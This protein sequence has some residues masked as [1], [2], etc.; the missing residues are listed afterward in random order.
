[1]LVVL[2]VLLLCV[3][4][5][6]RDEGREGGTEGGSISIR[7]I[8]RN[9]YLHVLLFLFQF[10][11]WSAQRASQTPA[12]RLFKGVVR[13]LC[14]HHGNREVGITSTVTGEQWR[15]G[16]PTPSPTPS[17]HS[18]QQQLSSQAET[19]G[20]WLNC[21]F[22]IFWGRWDF[23]GQG[24]GVTEEGV[25]FT[26][27][28][29]LYSGVCTSERVTYS[30]NYQQRLTLE[31]WHIKW[32]QEPLNP[33]QQLPA[34]YKRFTHDLKRNRQT[35]NRRI[36]N[37]SKTRIDQSLQSRQNWPI[38]TKTRGI[39]TNPSSDDDFS[40]DSEDDYRSCSWNVS[41]QQLSFWRQFSSGRSR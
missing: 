10:T 18:T 22:T 6:T 27:W 39:N 28:S 15:G 11:S 13:C 40:L 16:T 25:C 34:P 12:A 19:P 23:R 21:V 24:W 36:E 33:C 1:M 2:N 9:L 5:G 3:V 31:S 37:N 20:G 32:E 35:N 29:V 41:H 14:N 8:L 17:F 4:V 26:I 30:T 7:H 38:Q